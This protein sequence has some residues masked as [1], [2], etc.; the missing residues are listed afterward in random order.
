MVRVSTDLPRAR[1]AD[2]AEHLAAIEIE[3]E[4]V[5]HELVAEAD[6]QAAHPDDSLAIGRRGV[7]GLAQ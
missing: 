5:H 2:E 1:G 6:L 4:S 7:A 3:V